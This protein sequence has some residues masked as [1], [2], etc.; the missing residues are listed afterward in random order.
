MS[1]GKNSRFIMED[2]RPLCDCQ[3]KAIS[4]YMNYIYK[5]REQCV[6]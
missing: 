2:D 5:Q 3:E 1:F 4:V 6:R